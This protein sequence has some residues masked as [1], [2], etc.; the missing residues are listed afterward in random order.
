MLTEPVPLP[1]FPNRRWIAW[2]LVQLA[3]RIF[4][5]EYYERIL[6]KDA[7]GRLVYEAIIVG[8]LYG[9]GVSSIYGNDITLDAGSTVHWDDDYTPDWVD[10]ERA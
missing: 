5:A 7:E 4:D 3:A 6:I 8:D 1:R 10:W 9:N 2:K